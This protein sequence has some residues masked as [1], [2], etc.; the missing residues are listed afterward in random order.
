VASLVADPS[1]AA[2]AP[3]AAAQSAGPSRGRRAHPDLLVTLGLAALLVAI[4]FVARGGAALG[5]TTTATSALTLLGAAASAVA[6]LAGPSGRLWGGVTLLLFAAL[7]ALTA[8]SVAWSV[9]PED[10]WRAADLTLAY[11]AAFAGT[12]ALARIAAERWA[13]VIGAVVL[14]AVVVSGYAL[15][16][17]VFPS[18]SPLDLYARLRAP[19]DYWNAVGLM[20][21]LGIPGALWLGARREG[22]A[23]LG[24]LAVPALG[25]LLVTLLLAEGRGPLLAAG[26]ACAC[27]FAAAPLRLRGVAVLASAGAGAAIVC[28]WAFSQQALTTD[29]VPGALRADAGHSLGLLLLAMLVVLALAGLGLAFAM[30]RSTLTPRERRRL[31]ALL[32]VGLALVPVVGLAGLAASPRGLSGSISHGWRQLTDP[33]AQQPGN[34]PSRLTSVGG[35]RARYWDNGFTIWRRARWTGVGA[36]GYATARERIQPDRLR[37]RHAHG[38]VPQTLADLGLVG[39]GVSLA[40]LLA[41]LA[42][43]ARATGLRPRRRWGAW[44]LA[45]ARTRNARLRPALRPREPATPERIGLITLSSTAIAFGVHSAVDWT[46][47]VPGTAVTGLLCAAWVAA[48]GPAGDRPGPAALPRGGA[49]W[50]AARGRVALALAIAAAGLAGAWAIWQ[51]QRAASANDAALAA[52][53]AGRL[54]QAQA[55]AARAARIDP[56]SLD[57]LFTLAAT[58]TRAGQPA[59]ARATLQRAVRLQP[60]NPESWLRLGELELSQGD[61]REA[62]SVL[63]AAVYLD[64]QGPAAQ[65]TYAQAEAAAGGAGSP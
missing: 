31:G 54:A 59:A 39:L 3:A 30:A 60:A 53:D 58:E 62:L 38:Y 4:A 25:L 32:L 55:D 43:A 16:A 57:P 12:M 56:L 10:S 13:A 49:A 65:S 64:P 36:D 6:A 51:P 63:N 8:L 40:L 5:A 1:G 26:V 28:A 41:W 52:L 50:R 20:A 17:K 21:A 44:L 33:N 11:L 29:G 34:D 48:R 19:F 35:V 45:L 23:A 47:F 18:I 61:A 37:V 42:A 14:A 15:L 27:W 2:A 24:A 9:A 7:A 46:W 22:H